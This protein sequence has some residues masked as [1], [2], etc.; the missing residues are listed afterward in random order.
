MMMQ[1]R[2][3]WIGLLL[4]TAL[5]G[6]APAPNAP[7]KPQTPG[8]ND[9]IASAQPADW[10]PV[11]ADRLLILTLSGNR[12]V[13]IE[14]A[15]QLA[16]LNAGNIASLARAGFYDGAHIYRSQDNYVV[17]M[18]NEHLKRAIPEGAGATV[19]GEYL[20]SGLAGLPF[21]RLP[22]ADG[23]APQTGFTDGFPVGRDPKAGTTWMAHCYGAVG[24]G[25]DN[26]PN[27]GGTE[28]Y[29]ITGH[30]PRHLDRNI[31]LFGF[32][33]TGMEHLSVLPRGP[34]PMGF[35]AAPEQF[36]TIESIRLAST[37]PD[38]ER[39]LVEV[40]RTDT[41]LWQ[42]LVNARAN[43]REAWFARPAG[44]VELCN[45]AVPTRIVR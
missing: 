41:A 12:R 9:L 42:R 39:P 3:A 6:A 13:L 18:G 27:S 32:V 4:G 10:R 19:P 14:L 5:L 23:Y 15:P 34:A 43:R 22:F 37:L 45:V 8:V 29:A 26:D 28:F 31:T 21:T 7:P 38:A 20:R 25:R 35:Y 33:R 11:A 30:A 1:W 36:T 40:L 17:Q 44:F 24:M 16:P 2:N